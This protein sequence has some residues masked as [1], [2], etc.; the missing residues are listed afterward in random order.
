MHFDYHV[1]HA[2]VQSRPIKSIRLVHSTP[3]NAAVLGT[4]TG[5]FA[6]ILRLIDI[7]QLRRYFHINVYQPTFVISCWNLFFSYWLS[8]CPV[9]IVSYSWSFGDIRN[10]L[11]ENDNSQI[12]ILTNGDC[13]SQLI[14]TIVSPFSDASSTNPLGQINYYND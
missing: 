1:C 4:I 10:H 8:I 5:W 2:P 6:I 7:I 3:C 14:T 9:R 13:S 12:W 11:S